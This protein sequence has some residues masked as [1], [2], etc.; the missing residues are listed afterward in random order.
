MSK[1][2]ISHLAALEGLRKFASNA[3]PGRCCGIVSFIDSSGFQRIAFVYLL[4]ARSPGR[5]GSQNRLLRV[6]SDGMVHARFAINPG[7]KITNRELYEYPAI[8]GLTTRI[9]ERT[10]ARGIVSNG[11]H[12]LV[13]LNANANNLYGSLRGQTYEP[14]SLSTPRIA[15]RYDCAHTAQDPLAEM[16]VIRRSMHGKEK[17][18]LHFSYDD[19]EAGTGRFIHTYGSNPSEPSDVPP[20]SGEPHLVHVRGTDSKCIARDFWNLFQPNRVGYR[21]IRVSIAVRSVTMEPTSEPE[22]KPDLFIHNRFTDQDLGDGN[23][24][25]VEGPPFDEAND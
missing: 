14:D 25:L 3:Y 13:H 10:Y 16:L 20:F 7:A 23:D 2:P 8:A 18:V 9:L 17:E 21:D 1:A 5:G 15:A 6:E 19:I 24:N 22:G 12:T 4:T 11:N